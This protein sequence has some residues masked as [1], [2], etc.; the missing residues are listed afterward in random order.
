[1]L[2][3]CYTGMTM[4]DVWK[5]FDETALTHSSI[6]HLLAIKNLIKENGYSRAVDISNHLNISR[7]SVSITVTKLKDKGFVREDKNRFLI[8]SS[9]GERLVNS[10]MS[11]RRVVEQFFAEVLDLPTQEAEVEACKIEHLLSEP[12]GKRLIS[13]MGYYLSGQQEVVRFR[14]GLRSF[15]HLCGT[16]TDCLVCENECFY[17][18]LEEN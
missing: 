3:K 15:N 5:K 14:D 1:M 11:K 6:H 4:K 13:F 9:K 10:V 2:N 7:A 12:T 8:L 17:K 16:T 18:G